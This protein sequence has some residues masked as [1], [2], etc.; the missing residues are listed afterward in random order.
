VTNPVNV[1]LVAERTDSPPE[2]HRTITVKNDGGLPTGALAAPDVSGLAEPGGGAVATSTF[3]V[4]DDLCTG[5]LLAPGATCTFTLLLDV[6]A[7][8]NSAP[9]TGD[10]P[11]SASPGG[12]THISV[13]GR[14]TSKLVFDSVTDL[15]AT[16]TPPTDGSTHFLVTND[17]PTDFGPMSSTLVDAGVPG[18]SVGTFALSTDLD[19]GVPACTDGMTLASGTSCQWVVSYTNTTGAG[20]DS[21]FLVF[22]VP[23][24]VHAQAGFTG[25]GQP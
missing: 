4:S 17:G 22:D 25:T 6:A 12:T 10:L 2:A 16:A 14:Y 1:S 15:V 9:W 21:A 20:S 24:V 19:F 8:A 13:T 11:I 3:S 23:G 5:Q 7:Y 18:G